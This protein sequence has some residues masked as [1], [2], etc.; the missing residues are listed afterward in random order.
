MSL[1]HNDDR[2]YDRDGETALREHRKRNLSVTELDEL[3]D[4]QDI[5]NKARAE[6]AARQSTE[7]SKVCSPKIS[8]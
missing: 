1:S 5:Q 3:F 4:L 6:E 2:W 7:D 8:E